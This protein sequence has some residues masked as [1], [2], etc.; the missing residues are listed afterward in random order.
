MGVTPMKVTMNALKNKNP[1]LEEDHF[2]KKSPM[3]GKTMETCNR[4]SQ[5]L[6]IKLYKKLKAA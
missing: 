5:M 1:R 6:R 4:A 2:P 3:R